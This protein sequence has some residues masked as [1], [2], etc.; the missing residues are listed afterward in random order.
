MR[1]FQALVSFPQM[2]S[3]L[4]RGDPSVSH[5]KWASLD[6]SCSSIC[7]CPFVGPL[8]YNTNNIGLRFGLFLFGHLLHDNLSFVISHYEIDGSMASAGRTGTITPPGILVPARDKY[9]PL[10]CPCDVPQLTLRENHWE[11]CY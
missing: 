3:V 9:G 11:V 8:L 5:W 10:K 4:L 1:D 6:S 7:I 2:N